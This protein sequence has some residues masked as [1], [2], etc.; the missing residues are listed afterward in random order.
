MNTITIKLGKAE[1]DRLVVWLKKLLDIGGA[2][3]P[4]VKRLKST[5]DYIEKCILEE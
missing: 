4:Q 2:G 3:E 1:A 5:M